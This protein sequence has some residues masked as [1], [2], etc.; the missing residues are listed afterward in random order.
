MPLDVP[1][2]VGTQWGERENGREERWEEG[3]DWE[4]RKEGPV[5]ML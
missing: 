4:E 2:W 3:R 1:V 5:I